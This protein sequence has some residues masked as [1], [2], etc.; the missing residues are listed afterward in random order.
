ML[1]ARNKLS[2]FSGCIKNAVCPL[3]LQA[4]IKGIGK[5]YNEEFCS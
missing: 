1:A 5:Y 2:E 4:L 3:A